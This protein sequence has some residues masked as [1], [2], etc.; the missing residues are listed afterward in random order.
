MGIESGAFPLSTVLQC[1]KFFI[2]RHQRPY[3]WSEEEVQAL[4][5]DLAECVS[6]K[7]KEH[8]LGTIMLINLPNKDKDNEKREMWELNDGQQR[9]ITFGLICAQLCVFFRDS[10][11]SVGEDKML[12]ILFNRG[13]NPDSNMPM[14]M[15][16]AD[17]YSPRLIL[18]KE[19]INY[20][21][22]IRG[23]SVYRNGKLVNAWKK[24]G[25]FLNDSRHQSKGWR[26]A[27]LTFILDRLIVVK[28]CIDSDADSTSVFETLNARGKPLEQI[29]LFG[30]HVYSYFNSEKEKERG[31]TVQQKMESIFNILSYEKNNE[32]FEYVRCHMQA[33]YGHI[34]AK[35]FYKNFKNY[36]NMHFSSRLKKADEVYSLVE[37]LANKHKI[38]IFQLLKKS[39]S[40]EEILNQ[41]TKD[42]KKTNSR[43]KIENYLQDI[44]AYT[45]AYPVMF[46]LISRYVEATD[47]NNRIKVA[48]LVYACGKLLSSFIQRASHSVGSF[49]PSLYEDKLAVLANEIMNSRCETA[50]KFLDALQKCDS[51]KIIIPNRPYIDTMKKINFS[52]GGASKAKYILARI[53][54]SVTK[55]TIVEY[56]C[57]LEHILPQG[58]IHW[59]GWKGFTQEQCSEYT[60][61]FGNLTLL[62]KEDNKPQKA[63]NSNFAAK[64][65]IYHNSHYQ[66][67]KDICEQEDWTPD[68]IEKRQQKLAEMAAEI[69][70]FKFS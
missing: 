64:K 38:A 54:E 33:L 26:E 28:V 69:W 42:A 5:D 6:E 30:A 68:M 1:G 20:E 15:D 45:I 16:C 52:S 8:F 13:E 23:N 24:I 17:E 31:D 11:Y 47:E 39:H 37:N 48:K 67:T 50:E 3:D 7:R 59:G 66:I 70:N 34:P 63:H 14:T 2:P 32:I 12:R 51:Y 10:G 9:I 44:R 49:R 21:N 65:R 43:R 4:L 18:R 29:H 19:K 36:L 57:S 58:K 22:I 60:Y 40:G 56:H 62:T 55:D 46:A 61:R 25:D 53:V 27:L 35:R 41:L